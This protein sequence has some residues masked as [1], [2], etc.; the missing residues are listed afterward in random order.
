[1]TAT[2]IIA[3]FL[4]ILCIAP[5]ASAA[6]ISGEIYDL[7][8]ELSENVHISINTQPVQK[9]LVKD[10][11]YTFDVPA[12]S[13]EL[14]AYQLGRNSEILASSKEKLVVSAEG[15]FTRDIIL[16]P[17]VEADE[18]Y[19]S[20]IESFDEEE[21][22]IAPVEEKP[23]QDSDNK[24]IYYILGVLAIIIIIDL[25]IYFMLKKKKNE[26]VPEE[27]KVEPEQP[28]SDEKAS[29]DAPEP[30]PVPEE[31]EM[32]EEKKEIVG[33]IEQAGGRVTQKE[34]RQ[35]TSLSEAKVSL[36][37]SELEEDKLV[38]KIKKGRGNIIILNNE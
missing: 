15:D 28:K 36:I 29:E 24:L 9:V 38:R 11:T 8:L 31:K 12:G 6:T 1:M 2:R 22:A 23:K 26:P 5:F 20:D 3:L 37:L 35:M 27:G 7:D 32:S 14:H 16:V 21:E 30:A 34:L 17:D 10:G 13:Y 33:H 18:Q 25:I 19:L 4:F